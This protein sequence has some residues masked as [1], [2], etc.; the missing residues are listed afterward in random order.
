VRCGAQ[1]RAVE[2]LNPN[3]T[4]SGTSGAR[5][6]PESLHSETIWQEPFNCPNAARPL[7]VPVGALGNTE[8]FLLQQEMRVLLSDRDAKE[9]FGTAHVT[10]HAGDLIGFRGISVAQPPKMARLFR[11]TT[12]HPDFILIAGGAQVLCQPRFQELLSAEVI[13]ADKLQRIGSRYVRH[14]THEEAD[15]FLLLMENDV[16]AH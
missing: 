8:P 13:S 3:D 10:V 5:L 11:I 6:R 4:V 14:L 2:E 7:L 15:T 12:R 9:A 16:C 1:W